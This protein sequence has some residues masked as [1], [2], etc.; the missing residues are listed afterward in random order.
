MLA[1]ALKQNSDYNWHLPSPLHV[2][3]DIWDGICQ[4]LNVLKLH[5]SAETQN[6]NREYKGILT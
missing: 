2:R 6:K 4:Y 1:A 5:T 3:D